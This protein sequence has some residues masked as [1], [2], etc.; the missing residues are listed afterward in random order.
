M[1][2][3]ALKSTNVTPSDRIN[4][5][6]ILITAS[7]LEIYAHIVVV[8]LTTEFTEYFHPPIVARWRHIAVC[9]VV[10]V[11]FGDDLTTWPQSSRC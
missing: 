9:E 11:C 3:R 10:E 6:E 5:K 2:T 7:G 4:M 8:S 1:R